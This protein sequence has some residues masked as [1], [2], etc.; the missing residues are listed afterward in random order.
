M[1]SL[2][3]TETV[4]SKLYP[5]VRYVVRTLNVI[6]RARRDAKIAEARL[7]YSRLSTEQTQLYTKLIGDR[8]TPFVA[9]LKEAVAK[10]N[11]TADHLVSKGLAKWMDEA[12]FAEKLAALPAADQQKLESVMQAHNLIY[13]ER[14]L[15]A[16]IEASLIRVEGF[17]ID[18]TAATV[19]QVLEHAPDEMLAEVYQACVNATAL[20]ET[21]QKN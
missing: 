3:T 11:L 20:V 21:D 6:Q 16:T 8:T 5:G 2:K 13:Q 14:I 12:E 17:E 19:E 18:G 9:A 15:P 10:L 1:P 7:E 4:D